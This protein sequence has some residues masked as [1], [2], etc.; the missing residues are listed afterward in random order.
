[1]LWLMGD[2]VSV[3]ADIDVATGRYGDCDEYGE[4]LLKFADGAIGVL[5]GGWVDLADPMP[6]LISGTE[7]HAYVCNGQFYFQSE[8]V[9]GADGKTPWTDLPSDL[10][11]A[12]EL[13]L[14]ALQGKDVPLV[15]VREAAMR[16][17]V[18]EAMY[19]AARTRAW[20]TL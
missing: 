5:A 16:N 12:F 3:T 15:G 14:D 1:M 13:Y 2:P 7:G 6:M 20:V 18:M 10:P 8:H 17:A 4:A 19:E 11:H 9:A